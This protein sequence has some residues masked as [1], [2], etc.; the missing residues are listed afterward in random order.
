VTLS[1]DSRE[2]KRLSTTTLIIAAVLA[3]AVQTGLA[4]SA[5]ADVIAVS[6]PPVASISSPT[7]ALSGT[8]R[9]SSDGT[10]RRSAALWI[11]YPDAT[12]ATKVGSV[13]SRRPGF[14]AIT[15]RID[16][17]RIVPG[18]NQLQLI[19]AADGS[20]RTITVDLRRE[21]RIAIT[22]AEFRTRERVAVAVRVQH[23]DPKQNA[24]IA[25]R[26]SPVHVQEKVDGGWVTRAELTTD[27]SGLAG[28]VLP[29]ATAGNHYYRAIRPDGATVWTATSLTVATRAGGTAT[30][31]LP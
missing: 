25:S 17:R 6:L 7:L 16:A 23:F 22:H 2:V 29:A 15:A 10:G 3:T 11:R 13:T 28:V 8:V 19:D 24:F 20:S 5:R 18:P 4:G 21:T 31:L 1:A 14:L 27:A 26:L 30:T 9:L 12:A